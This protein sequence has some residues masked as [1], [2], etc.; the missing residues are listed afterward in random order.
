MQPDQQMGNI[1]KPRFGEAKDKL[2]QK[3]KKM[4][5]SGLGFK[6]KRKPKKAQSRSKC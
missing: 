2:E 3:I 1:F 4:T 6:R 5:G